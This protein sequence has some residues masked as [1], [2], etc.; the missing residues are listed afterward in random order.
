[1]ASGTNKNIAFIATV[2][3]VIPI[4]VG[5]W[6]AAPIFL[7]MYR[8]FDVDLRGISRTLRIPEKT[9]ATEFKLEVR[10]NPRGDGDPAPWQI[11][12]T[13]PAWSTLYPGEDNDEEKLLVRCQMLSANDGKPPATTFINNTYQDRYF[14]VTGLRLP[15]GSLPGQVAKRPVLIYR[16]LDMTK[17]TINEGQGWRSNVAQWENDDDWENRDDGWRPPGAQ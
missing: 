14:H 13:Q 8:W 12:D 16:P 11:L 7:P 17:M 4:L 6:F 10:Y 5:A 15:P 2:A 9:L 1:M 3:V